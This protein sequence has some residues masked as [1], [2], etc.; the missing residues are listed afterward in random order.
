MALM[1]T[2]V[3]WL[4]AYK[5]LENEFAKHDLN[6]DER[7][8]RA[9]ISMVRRARLTNVAA[10]R[11]CKLTSHP[12]SLTT[13]HVKRRE[14]DRAV[15]LKEEM[16]SKGI[17]PSKDVRTRGVS[18]AGCCC[19][20]T[21]Y[22]QAMGLLVHGHAKAN[23]LRSAFDTLDEMFRLDLECPERHAFLLREKCKSMGVWHPLVPAHPYAW[24]FTKRVTKMRK[25]VDKR[26]RKG[27]QD[28]KSKKS[29]MGS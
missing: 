24:Q 6:P 28:L 19:A 20:H 13:Q 10:R 2:L 1:F 12:H 3:G 11:P 4:Q 26:T 21:H 17:K 8:Y 9:L 18:A 25:A 16:L 7:T 29:F 22:A 27:A 5:F 23:N 14:L 15:E